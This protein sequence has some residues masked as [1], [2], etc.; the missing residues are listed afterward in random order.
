MLRKLFLGGQESAALSRLSEATTIPAC[1]DESLRFKRSALIVD[2]D[3]D[4][5]PIVRLALAR[6]HFDMESAFDG[7]SGLIRLRARDFDLVILDLGMADL[8][9][10]E[11]LQTMRK[12]KRWR[13]IPVI[14]LTG[15]DSDEALA[16]SFGY[17]AD[18]FVTK[19]FKPGELGIRAY[20]LVQPLSKLPISL[21]SSAEAERQPAGR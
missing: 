16:R 13:N 11:V 18:D 19:P 9:G 1:L 2:D 8:D 17:G 21:G 6:F 14:V 12:E 5:P 20:R 4:I 15:D 7:A 3:P 10:F